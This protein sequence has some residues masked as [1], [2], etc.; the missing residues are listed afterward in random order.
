[1]KDEELRKLIQQTVESAVE[2]AIKGLTFTA[3][4][5]KKE[6]KTKPLFEFKNG[7]HFFYNDIEFIRLGEEQGGI[8]AMTAESQGECA[9][10]EGGSDYYRGSTLQGKINDWF[11]EHMREHT[12]DICHFTMDLT[13]NA[14]DEDYGACTVD[15]GIL[16]ADLRQKYKKEIGYPRKTN[17]WT[18]TPWRGQQCYAGNVYVVY[19]SGYSGDWF[20][21]L[22]CGFAPACIFKSSVS[23]A[24]SRR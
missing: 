14:G 20:A 2:E 11:I 22:T 5:T 1:M 24:T 15:V 16:S 12:N 23:V 4:P 9:F 13:S 17:E 3:E 6:V 18:C 7:E 19:S 10:D 8:L 21:C